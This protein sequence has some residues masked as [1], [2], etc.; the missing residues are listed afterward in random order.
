[1]EIER[2]ATYGL[3]GAIGVTSFR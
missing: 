3:I 2:A 1:M